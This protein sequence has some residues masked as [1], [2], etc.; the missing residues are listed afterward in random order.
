MEA[1]MTTTLTPN[2][3]Q[4]TKFKLMNAFFVREDDG[5]TLVDTTMGAADA[6]IAA[7]TEAGA[8]IARI[9]LTHGHGD[10]VGSLDALHAK[11]GAEV[12]VLMPELDARILAGEQVSPNQNKGTWPK[13]ATKPD[14]LLN[15]GDRVG[16]LEV[17]ASP[18]HTPG[19]VAFLDTRD[20]S[21]I[22]GDAF[23]SVGGLSVPSHPH[24]IFPLPWFATG[25]RPQALVSAKALAALDPS[26]IVVGH[27]PAIASPAAAMAKAIASAER[28]AS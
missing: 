1:E 26:L 11:L 25:D 13:L 3:I 10:H 23:S 4:F 6:L 24:W 7:A 20:G 9:A 18:G 28:A 16:S 17:V 12:P 8:P 14:V 22:A 15:A 21:L 19:H 27:G 2:L 5:L